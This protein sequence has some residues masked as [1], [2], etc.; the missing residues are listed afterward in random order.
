MADVPA[1]T[2]YT[3]PGAGGTVA[4]VVAALDHTPPGVASVR[5]TVLPAHTFSGPKMPAGKGLTVTT[6]VAVAVPQLN[7]MV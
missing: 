5:S 2:P 4:T 3:R 6:V 1:E 7:V